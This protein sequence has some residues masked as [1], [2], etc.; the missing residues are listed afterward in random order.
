[1]TLGEMLGEK[2]IGHLIQEQIDEY[3]DLLSLCLTSKEFEIPKKQW[4]RTIHNKVTNKLMD[5]V[6]ESC[7]I[8]FSMVNAATTL[9][10]L[11]RADNRDNITILTNRLDLNFTMDF[12]EN[13]IKQ[14]KSYY[15][16]MMQALKDPNVHYTLPSPSFSSSQ[17]SMPW[18]FKLP[19]DYSIHSS[20]FE[21]SFILWYAYKTCNINMIKLALYHRPQFMLSPLS[22]LN[23][24]YGIFSD[25]ADKSKIIFHMPSSYYHFIKTRNFLIQDQSMF[26]DIYVIDRNTDPIH[27]LTGMEL[28]CVLDIKLK[29]QTVKSEYQKRKSNFSNFSNG[30]TP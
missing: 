29:V 17:Y 12:F 15:N 2:D 27:Y 6:N 5:Y 16:V 19:F 14:A 21:T 8:A 7:Y 28:L 11:F 18:K 22:F 23:E 26:H 13:N 30:S 25:C 4:L 24:T 20:T 9:E 1:M 3:D 10:D